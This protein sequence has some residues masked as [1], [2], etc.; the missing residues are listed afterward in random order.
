MPPPPLGKARAAAH[1]WRDVTAHS[2]ENGRACAHGRYN[3]TIL[4]LY[5]NNISTRA[6]PATIKD[7]EADDRR[8]Q[9]GC[10][11]GLRSNNGGTRG[12]FLRQ[13]S[14]AGIFYVG[15]FGQVYRIIIVRELL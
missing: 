14:C 7:R 8:R 13:V 6:Q 4:Y 15:Y 5:N 10:V 12:V 11:R 1:V 3:N 9:S 2:R